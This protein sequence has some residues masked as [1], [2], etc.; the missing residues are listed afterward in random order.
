MD[1]IGRVAA[2]VGLSE[3]DIEMYGSYKAKITLPLKATKSTKEKLI[4]V[5]SINQLRP[6]KENL[7]LQLV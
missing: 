5:T 4:L 7:R 6:E 1:K 3:D 2:Q